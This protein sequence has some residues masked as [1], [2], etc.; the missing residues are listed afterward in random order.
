MNPNLVA[1]A[2]E[3]SQT[4]PGDLPEKFLQLDSRFYYFFSINYYIKKNSK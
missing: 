1:L 3:L 4:K 2:K